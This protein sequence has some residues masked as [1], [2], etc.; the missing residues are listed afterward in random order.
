MH[1]NERKPSEFMLQSSEVAAIKPLT[2]SSVIVLED[3]AYDA[4]IAALNAPV[5]ANARLKEL[6]VRL[7]LWEQ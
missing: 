3:E 5:E 2:K 7:P 4:F 6:M 1:D